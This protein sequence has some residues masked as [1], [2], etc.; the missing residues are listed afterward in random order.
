M[1]PEVLMGNIAKNKLITH[2]KINKFSILLPFKSLKFLKT[3]KRNKKP[4]IDMLKNPTI[5]VSAKICK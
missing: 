1:L 4:I 3:K 5:P 2:D